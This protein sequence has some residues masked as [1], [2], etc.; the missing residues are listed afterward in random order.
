[1]PSDGVDGNCFQLGPRGLPVASPAPEIL[2]GSLG[3]LDV[4]LA[5]IMATL[6]YRAAPARPLNRRLAMLLIV[7]G[8]AQLVIAAHFVPSWDVRYGIIALHLIAA[9]VFPLVYLR[10]LAT[11]GTRVVSPLRGR[12]LQV[13]LAV[14][15]A[16]LGA[17]WLARPA[18]FVLPRTAAQPDY[19][20]GPAALALYL[21]VGL[22]SIYGLVASIGVFRASP[23]KSLARKR[24]I[25]FILAFG[26]RD[27]LFAGSLTMPVL[28]NDP[29]LFGGYTTQTVFAF[30]PF[31]ATLFFVLLMGYGILRTQLFEV[32]SGVTRTVSRTAVGALFLGVFLVVSQLAQSFAASY[33][34]ARGWIAG[35]IAA[36]LLVFAL[37]P[38]QRA[39]ERIA[40]FAL[41]NAGP[42]SAMSHQDRKDLYQEQL[43]IAWEDGTLTAKER[44]LL[45]VA[46]ERLGLTSEEVVGLEREVLGRLAPAPVP[47]PPS[48]A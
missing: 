29:A 8:G 7:E 18:A 40:A 46:G 22:V 26:A 32:G 1:M 34:G 9:I 30:A 47:I 43:R 6:I 17:V 3:V 42:V 23:P 39:A 16:G 33:F 31:A 38:L 11:L 28:L 48:A 21:V 36:G 24:A 12:S 20:P 27:L 13:V 25:S 10:F 19:F 5:W 35:G 44:H 41:P 4:V 2:L 14:A 15:T 37:V 45:D